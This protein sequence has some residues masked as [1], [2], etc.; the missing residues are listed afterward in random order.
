MDERHRVVLEQHGS[1]R[2]AGRTQQVLAGFPWCCMQSARTALNASHPGQYCQLLRIAG[3]G[4]RRP[5]A[6]LQVREARHDDVRIG[7]RAGDGRL[8]EVRQVAARHVQRAVQPQPRVGG[9]LRRVP[10]RGMSARA[11]RAS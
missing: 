1:T 5:P 7:L 9:H 4:S 10:D 11:W 8:D 3:L 2:A 6:R